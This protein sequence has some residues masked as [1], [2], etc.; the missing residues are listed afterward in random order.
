MRVFDFYVWQ[1]FKFSASDILI[2]ILVIGLILGYGF[3]KAVRKRETNPLYK[4]YFPG[5][6]IKMIASVIFCLVYALYYRDGGDTVAYWWGAESLKNLFYSNWGYFYAEMFTNTSSEDFFNHYDG[7]TGWPPGWLYRSD[8][9]FFVCKIVSCICIFIPGSFLGVSCFMGF[10]SYHGIWKLFET[11]THHFPSLTKNLRWAVLFL[12]STLFWCSGI[13]KDTFVLTGVCWIVY[14]TDQFLRP[15]V[16]KNPLKLALR[17]LIWGWLILSVKPYVIIALAPAWL[18]WMNYV[19]LSKIKSTLLKYYLIPIVFVGSSVLIF[20]LYSASTLETEYSP[21][22]V[23]DRAMIVRNDFSNNETYGTNRYKAVEVDNSGTGLIRALPEALIAGMFRPF[24]WEARSPFIFLS[25]LENVFI[26]FYFLYALI[27]LRPRGFAK[28]IGSHPLILF[29]FIFSVL[30]AF[31]VGFTSILFGVLI[32]FRTPFL[33]FLMSFVIIAAGKLKSMKMVVRYS[34][35]RP[36][37]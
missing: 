29:S 15:D 11:L 34:S 16:R 14:E 9:H 28:F 4:Y 36:N 25:A 18:I 3:L 37:Q 32:R 27:K 7:V 23:V 31:I 22:N 1:N 19:P 24:I 5:L 20:Q 17:V 30:L 2:G 12:P 33:P 8:R 21:D 35:I 26:L 13:M 10:I 6:V